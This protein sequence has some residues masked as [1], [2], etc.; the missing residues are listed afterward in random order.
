MKLFSLFIILLALSSCYEENKTVVII[1]SNL[2]S[3]Q[4]MIGILTEIQIA[5]AG[6]SINKNRKSS[7]ELKPEYYNKALEQHSIT[8]KQFKENTNYYHNYPK[9]MENIY[10][11]VLANLSQIQNSVIKEKEAFDEKVKADSITMI[12]DS[13]KLILQDSTQIILAD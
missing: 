9:I 13:I 11:Q 7:N 10:E 12:E 8:L 1:P 3:E 6:F 2:L 4:Q 5:E